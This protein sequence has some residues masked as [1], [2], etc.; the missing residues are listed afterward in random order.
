MLRFLSSISTILSQYNCQAYIVGG[1]VRDW[2]LKRET[3]DIDIA[4]N[5]DAPKLAQDVASIINGKYVLL[6]KDNRIAKVIAARD[7]QQWQLD[8]A[9][10]SGSIEHDL[11]RR[12]FTVDA[13][14]MELQEFVSGSP[15][16]I[17]PFSGEADLKSS[18]IRAVS[19]HI[20]EEDAVRLLRAI[21]LAAELGFRIESVTERLIRESCQLARLVPGERLREELLRLLALPNSYDLIRYANELGLLTAIIPELAEL[22]GVEQPKEH[23]WNVFDHSVETV[24]AVEF[25]L[26]ENDWKYGKGDLLAVTPWSEEISQHIN[27]EVSSGSKR[28]TLL[29]LGGLLHDIAKPITRTVD[30]TGKM[31]F[32]GH[33]KQGAAMATA[34]LGRLRFSTR[35]TTLVESLVYHHLRPAQ[36]ANEGLPTRRAIYRYFRDTKDAGVDVLLIAL[37][38][39]LATNGPRLDINEWQQHNQLI[40]YILDE[41]IRQKAQTLPVKLIDG[42]DLIDG[43]GL[44]PG[45]L[46]RELL[47]RVSEAHAVGEISTREEAMALVRKELS[48]QQEM[49][50]NP[51]N[52]TGRLV[53]QTAMAKKSKIHTQNK[54]LSLSLPI[55]GRGIK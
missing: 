45:P 33:T 44:S 54:A 35:E 21:R 11:A 23:Y 15:R 13:M 40:N 50:P 49:K 42:H 30:E 12:D 28:K 47:T 14:A 22:K 26:R 53:L 31:R 2:L 25:L 6:D 51:D 55:Q 34:I 43:L 48:K 3:V 32:L 5:C 16:L 19:P 8:F 29:K 41:H 9:S 17:D 52:S 18:L 27:E 4:V 20:F 7:E 37:A 36:I 46:I 1:F 24:A 10:F 39:Y 38:D